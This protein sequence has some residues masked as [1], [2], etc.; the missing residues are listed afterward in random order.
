MKSL[1]YTG[2][3]DLWYYYYPV[4][5]CLAYNAVTVALSSIAELSEVQYS[6]QL[7]VMPILAHAIMIIIAFT[8]TT[9][10]VYYHQQFF[11]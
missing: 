3:G 10:E 1:V 9:D 8:L 4:L 7:K 11:L 6:M 5:R 2:S